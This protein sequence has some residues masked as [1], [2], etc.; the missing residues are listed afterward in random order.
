MI[1]TTFVVHH[2]CGTL[3]AF[4]VVTKITCR[5]LGTQVILF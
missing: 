5:Y 3:V 2:C 4:A 1:T